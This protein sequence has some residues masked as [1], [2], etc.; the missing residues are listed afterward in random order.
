GQDEFDNFTPLAK[1]PAELLH[2]FVVNFREVKESIRPMNI[3]KTRL[4][5]KKVRK[6][7]MVGWR[8]WLSL[9]ELGIARI[10]AKVDSGARTSALHA[11][12][13]K[14][15]KHQEKH[16]IR[17][18]IHPLQRSKENMVECMAQVQD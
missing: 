10:K 1:N 8:E 13:I 11:F 16:Y 15:F 6:L 7:L 18:K 5:T 3:Q 9:P 14:P 17:F 12:E 4:K 2:F